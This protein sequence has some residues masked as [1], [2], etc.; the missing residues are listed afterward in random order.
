M[1][2]LLSQ[3]SGVQLLGVPKISS[4]SGRNM[5]DAVF[6]TLD[7]WNVEGNIIGLCFDITNS[8]SGQHSGAAVILESLLQRYLLLLA[9]RHHLYEIM[10]RSAYEVRFGSP[11]GPSPTIFDRFEIQWKSIDQSK[12]EPGI[13]NDFIK[14]NLEDISDDIMKFCH[15][16]L[17]KNIIRDDYKEILELTLIFHGKCSF[18]RTR[19]TTSRKVDV[20][21]SVCFKNI[22]VRE[23]V[24]GFATR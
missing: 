19:S 21:S 18:S 15:D 13:R 22:Y 10:L 1:P 23:I 24:F 8:N 12:Y 9:C 7:E 14:S 2:V 5:A 11:S 17:Q 16:E 20:Q 6:T 4:S 3:E